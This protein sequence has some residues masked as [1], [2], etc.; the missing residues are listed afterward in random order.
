MT[1]RAS[2]VVKRARKTLSA[3]PAALDTAVLVFPLFLVY[4][5]GIV[6]G[7]RNGADVVTTL[8]MRLVEYDL[9]LPTILISPKVQSKLFLRQHD[10]HS[11]NVLTVMLEAQVIWTIALHGWIEVND[12]VVLSWFCIAN[13]SP[14]DI[15]VFHYSSIHSNIHTSL[16]AG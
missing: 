6:S 1:E 14:S 5:V 11:L 2:G 16:I 9:V 13:H 10:F 15:G 4:Q 12:R 3:R 7:V 8:L